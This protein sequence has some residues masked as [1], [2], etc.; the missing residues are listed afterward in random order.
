MLKSKRKHAGPLKEA[1]YLLLVLKRVM[2]AVSKSQI[3]VNK[4]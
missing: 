1:S 4:F 3:L 2:S